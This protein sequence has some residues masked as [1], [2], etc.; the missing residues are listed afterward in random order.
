MQAP[1][2]SQPALDATTRPGD[3]APPR[4]VR[5]VEALRRVPRTAWICALIACLNAA[6]WSIVTFA[7]QVPDEPAHFAYVKQLAEVGRPPTPGSG[8]Y[9]EEEQI[10]LAGLRFEDVREQQQNLAIA[11][12]AEQ[13]EMRRDLALASETGE[14]GSPGAGVAA[15]EPPLYYALETIP[16]LIAQGGSIL[17]RL[18]LM[19]LT[20]ALLAGLTAMFTFMFIREALPGGPRWSWTVGGLGIALVPLLGFMCGAVNPDA[21]LFAVSAANFYGLARAFR[22]GLDTRMALTIGALLAIGFLTKL[23]FIGL[24]PGI[25]LGLIVLTIRRARVVGAAAYRALALALGIAF[26]PCV[27]Y[28][29]INALSNRPLLGLVSSAIDTVHGSVFSEANYIWQIYLPRLPGTVNDFPGLAMARELWFRGYVGLYGWFD[30]TFP[31]WVYNIALIPAFALALLCARG[32]P[33]ARAAW[34]G[35]AVEVAVYAVMC[36]GLMV[37]VGADSYHEFPRFD[38]AYAQVRYLLPLLPMLGVA[39]ALAARG[40]G[41]RWGPV[42]GTLIVVLFLAHEIF[43]QLLVVGRYYG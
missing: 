31:N 8:S 34:R 10:A 27:V 42:V 1:G 6:T 17:A 19:R 16:Y 4:R 15:S 23:S 12:A 28:V 13:L 41:R 22:R 7:F 33:R 35:R 5:L 36:L 2:T 30:T 11:S 43:S 18:E 14:K 20:S 24:A 38:A 29:A 40:G 39:L 37:L 3:G 21:L 25:L 9:S 32:L 26:S